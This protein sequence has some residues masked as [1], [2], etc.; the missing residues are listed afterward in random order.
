MKFGSVLG[1][2]HR[3]RRLTSS[4]DFIVTVLGTGVPFPTLDRFGA[5]ALV[6]AGTEILL[7]D[8]GRGTLQRLYQLNVN[9]QDA[10]FL[11]LTHLHADHS[12]G[13]PDLWLTPPVFAS[14]G[15][16]RFD[17]LQVMDQL[18]RP[19]RHLLRLLDA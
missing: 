15:F 14:R 13:I 19:D 18:E 16:D 9:L 12:T 8:W 10:R 2:C 7:F 6:L 17:T 3:T 1:R 11:F 4:R 5:S